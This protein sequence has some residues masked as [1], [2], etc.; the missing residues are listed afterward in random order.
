M[1]KQHG[2][3]G[4]SGFGMMLETNVDH[5][6]V[7]V[8]V[9]GAVGYSPYPLSGNRFSQLLGVLMS[10]RSQLNPFWELS[11]TKGSYHAQVHA[12]SPGM[13]YI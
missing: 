3:L 1:G 11:S 13:V 2:Q 12:P 6:V 9:I 5:S 4:D 10:M 8:G 7:D